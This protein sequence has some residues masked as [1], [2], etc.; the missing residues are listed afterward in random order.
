MIEVVGGRAAS[1][2][3]AEARA[4]EREAAC[5]QQL[6][7]TCVIV[8]RLFFLLFFLGTGVGGRNRGWQQEGQIQLSNPSQQEK[9]Q[10]KRSCFKMRRE[11]V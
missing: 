10:I 11:A 6:S 8:P 3:R 2:Q 9:K 4:S 5:R 7:M 1:K